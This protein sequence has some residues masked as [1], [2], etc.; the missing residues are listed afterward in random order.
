MSFIMRAFVWGPSIMIDWV[1]LNVGVLHFWM[2]F[3][4]SQSS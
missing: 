1:N 3:A 2:N 4:E